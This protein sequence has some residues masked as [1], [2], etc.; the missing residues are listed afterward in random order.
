MA[1]PT[2]PKILTMAF[3]AQGSKNDI[4]DTQANSGDGYAAFDTGFP[5]ET[6]IPIAAGG[7]PPRRGDMNGILNI[8]SSLMLYLGAGPVYYPFSNVQ[9]S[10]SGGYSLGAII[11]PDL[12][13]DGRVLVS[14]KNLNTDNPNND[15]TL[16]GSSWLRFD[17]IVDYNPGINHYEG[18]F[19]IYPVDKNCYRC[20]APHGPSINVV[21]PPTNTT[22]W[23]SLAD[24]VKRLLDQG[25]GGA[26]G[27]EA[28]K[29][30][31][32]FSRVGGSFTVPEGVTE[33]KI[34]LTGGGGS[35][36]MS[37][38]SPNYIETG[39]GAAGGTA[40]L[41]AKVI[42]GQVIPYTIGAGGARPSRG[43]NG[44]AGGNSTCL[45]LVA[46]GGMGGTVSNNAYTG[47]VVPG[48]V[49]T[50]GTINL[51]G[52]YGNWGLDYHSNV[53]LNHGGHGGTSYWGPGG[54]G[55]T[56]VAPVT[57]TQDAVNAFNP[58][59]GGG[60]SGESAYGD[61]LAGTGAA[62]CILLEWFEPTMAA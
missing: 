26:I 31:R 39:G 38:L 45:G 57:I 61:R 59:S 50:G 16:I 36:A 10:N 33:L 47:T 34:T 42:P 54:V 13:V 53:N 18:E 55:Q 8:M 30:N 27:G 29:S 32:L 35:G 28:A 23:E 22:Y 25:G 40:I 6:Q 24:Y 17:G 48:G 62:G 9:V 58:G 2:A 11:R 44:I 21:V 52:G 46:Y 14:S 60:G 12:E 3:A 43:Q 4:P 7:I 51:R 37:P 1:F 20:K 49:A 19:V 5:P 15:P 56:D 41:W